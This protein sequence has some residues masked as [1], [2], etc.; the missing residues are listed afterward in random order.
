[1]V[2]YDTMGVSGCIDIDETSGSKEC[3]TFSTD[4]F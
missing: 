3:I 4:I 2:Y 1:M